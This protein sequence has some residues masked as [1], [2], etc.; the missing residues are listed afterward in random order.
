M[1][2]NPLSARLH[3]I[4]SRLANWSANAMGS[5]AAFAVSTLAVI[6]WA[7]SGPL[8]GFSDTWQ[9]VVNTGTTVLTFLAV[10]LIQHSQNRD[11]LAIQLKLDELIRSTRRARNEL[12]DLETC[13]D[14][15]I[16]LIHQQLSA[17]RKTQTSA[18][19]D[20]AEVMA[21]EDAAPASHAARPS[22]ALA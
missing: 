5:P 15:E 10:F 7:A 11:G 1:D 8:F 18:A 13:S 9:L 4:F 19:E 14:E 12:I 22:K 21:E 6:V 16:A 3:E 17:L 2:K 20:S